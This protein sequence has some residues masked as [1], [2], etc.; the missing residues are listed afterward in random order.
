MTIRPTMRIERC[1]TSSEVILDFRS[2]LLVALVCVSFIVETKFR[3]PSK[4]SRH[5]SPR[6]S[7]AACEEGA[8]IDLLL[9][10]LW[11]FSTAAKPLGGSTRLLNPSIVILGTFFRSHSQALLC[12]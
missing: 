9:L 11:Q 10:L 12:A 7:H 2:D 3:L 8:I 1:A 5:R 6:E 4:N